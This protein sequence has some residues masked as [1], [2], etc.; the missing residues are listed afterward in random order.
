MR[1]LWITVV[2]LGLGFGLGCSRKPAPADST[3]LPSTSEPLNAPAHLDPGLATGGGG[4]GAAPA[5]AAPSASAP[6]EAPLNNAVPLTSPPRRRELGN[7]GATRS[8]ETG[9]AEGG[10]RKKTQ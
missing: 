1:K 2:M 4:P 7:L 3:T 5:E 8:Q 6:A 10:G 9:G